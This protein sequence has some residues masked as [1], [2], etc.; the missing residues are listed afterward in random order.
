MTEGLGS[1]LFVNLNVNRPSL[2]HLRLVV[3]NLLQFSSKLRTL[4]QFS[5]LRFRLISRVEQIDIVDLVIITLEQLR[6]AI[7]GPVQHGFA[8]KV[9]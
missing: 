5:S 6:A 2:P 7:T 1:L 8:L 4:T 3:S 9:K